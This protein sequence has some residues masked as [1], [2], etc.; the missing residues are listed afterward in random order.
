MFNAIPELDSPYTTPPE[1]PEDIRKAPM[2]DALV[3]LRRDQFRR[4]SNY[5]AS[6]P[7]GAY[8]GKVW[9]R[10]I[11][12]PAYPG[13]DSRQRKPNVW[14]LMWYEAHPTDP[15]L[16]SIKSREIRIGKVKVA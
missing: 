3:L 5:S 4:L 12:G 10:C 2:D 1:Q 9:K 7:S 8:P 16:C 11:P 6:I 14:L 13:G 15:K